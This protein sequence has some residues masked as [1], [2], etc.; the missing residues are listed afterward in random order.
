MVGE[1]QGKREPHLSRGEEEER[2][3]STVRKG[4]FQGEEGGHAKRTFLGEVGGS[5]SG[6]K[7][8][9][10]I[11]VESWFPSL[12]KPKMGKEVGRQSAYS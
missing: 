7:S 3:G 10:G 8:F 1:G 6:R 12:A 5:M 9:P 4:R 2:V 11:S